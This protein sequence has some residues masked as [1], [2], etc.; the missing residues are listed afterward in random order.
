MNTEIRITGRDGKG[1][2]YLTWSPVRAFVRLRNPDN[3]S[4]VDVV[5]DNQSTSQGGQLVFSKT[6]TGTSSPSLQVKLKANGEQ[7]IF[8]IAG[9]FGRP[10]L[11]DKDAVIR[12]RRVGSNAVLSTHPVMVRIRKNANAL[13]PPE[14]DRFVQAFATLNLGGLGPFTS[15]RDMHV[16]AASNEAHG[17][18]GFLPWH[19]AY[20]LDLERSLQAIDASVA[21]PY[22]KFDQPAPN[23]FSLNFF[24]VSDGMGSLAFAASNPLQLWR[25]DGGQSIRRS[26]DF[27]TN[28]GRPTFVIDEDTTLALGFPASLF[29]E[30][31]VL[32][33][34][35][36][37]EAHVSFSGDISSIG[38]AAKDPLFFLLHT[39]VDRL[40]AK[41]QWKNK[42]FNGTQTAT[43]PFGG[44]ASSAGS[45][46]VGHNLQDTMWP[47]NQVKTSPRP[48]TAPG[49]DFPRAPHASAPGKTPR[50]RSMI[51]F[52]GKLAM[53]AR[54][55]FDYDD[56]PLEF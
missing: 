2:N 11:A 44:A 13:T 4:P 47:W 27:N 8:W 39:N 19:R 42:R 10:S 9:R 5:I 14:R 49:G 3:A 15:F 51:D 31:T 30:F 36:H 55:G 16:S 32:E 20:L 21:L 24:G 12:V 23:L 46:R 52:Q 37:G 26:P 25:T 29:S 48:P 1:A 54:L 38:T 22:W 7:V 28:T 56:V 53:T 40:W 34:N 18:S 41:W 6:R 43:Y 45:T 35:P 50:V 33:G 17:L